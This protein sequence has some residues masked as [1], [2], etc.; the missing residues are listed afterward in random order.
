M[1]VNAQI[2]LL[3]RGLQWRL[4]SYSSEEIETS[5]CRDEELTQRNCGSLNE[6]FFLLVKAYLLLLHFNILYCIL[7]QV[8]SSTNLS[9]KKVNL[10]W[11]LRCERPTL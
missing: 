6:R 2:G 8:M 4:I 10:H 11:L 1:M 5:S 9:S 3:I 7:V